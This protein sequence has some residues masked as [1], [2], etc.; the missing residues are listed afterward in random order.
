MARMF[1]LG[2][3]L[4]LI[5]D[6]FDNGSMAQEDAIGHDHQA[7]LHVIAQLGDEL[8]VKQSSRDCAR[9]WEDSPCRQRA[10][11]TAS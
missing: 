10:C 9:G 6:T 4:E 3:V 7:V 11:Q 5:D 2:D 8:N 1:D